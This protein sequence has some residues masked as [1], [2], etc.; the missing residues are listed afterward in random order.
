[1]IEKIKSLLRRKS[2]CVLAT[3]D[4]DTPHCSLMAYIISADVDRM[5]FVTPQNTTKYQNIR[6]HPG[7]SLLIDTRG[8][9]RRSHTQALTI[10]GT[11]Q[12]LADAN[13]ISR[14]R[15]AF[16][17]HH[18]HLQGLIHKG[19]VAFLCVKFDSF[20]FLDGPENAYYEIPE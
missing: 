4:G 17:H 15:K 5:Y 13:E 7:V 16:K 20:L 19:R 3:T 9:Q 10:T 2:S 1:M 11:C 14:V 18:A 8:E 12:I 6:R